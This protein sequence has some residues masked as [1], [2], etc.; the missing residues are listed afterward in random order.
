MLIEIQWCPPPVSQEMPHAPQFESS[1]ERSLQKLVFGPVPQQTA[2][3]S[4]A[5]RHFLW[6]Q[7]ES[8]QSI[9]VS[10]SLSTPSEQVVS[11]LWPPGQLQ[12]PPLHLRPPVPH[13][14]PEGQSIVSAQSF[15]PS[16]SL[17]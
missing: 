1:E 11:E 13:V 16:Q 7:S 6:R 12:E 14:T 10:Q 8:A 4:E 3:S 17:S 15:T 5:V 2:T 9:A